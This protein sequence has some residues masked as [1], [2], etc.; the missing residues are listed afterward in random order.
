MFS[1]SHRGTHLYA[2]TNADRAVG[3]RSHC[4]RWQSV[5][6]QSEHRLRS[7]CVRPRRRL[8]ARGA[9]HRDQVC[10]FGDARPEGFGPKE[11]SVRCN[12]PVVDRHESSLECLDATPSEAFG[13]REVR[14]GS[15]G[16]R[17]R[18]GAGSCGRGIAAR[19]RTS[20]LRWW[21][22]TRDESGERFE[23]FGGRGG[24]KTRW[25]VPVSAA[26]GG[27]SDLVACRSMWASVQLGGRPV[28]VCVARPTLR[29][30][31]ASRVTGPRGT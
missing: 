29:R 17:G 10:H 15:G 20:P 30:R 9:A 22:R 24:P 14:S 26:H 31:S 11:I 18:L 19:V 27:S 2:V 6:Q 25:D 28:G 1:L 5:R 21:H 23:R 8:R 7:V 3:P 16:A 4:L 13:S 12:R